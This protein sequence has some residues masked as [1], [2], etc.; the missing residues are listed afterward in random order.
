MPL[1]RAGTTASMPSVGVL[2]SALPS[3]AWAL[4]W[5]LAWALAW[6][7]KRRCLEPKWLR[8]YVLYTS[9]FVTLRRCHAN[10]LCSFLLHFR[11]VT[12]CT[13]TTTTVVYVAFFAGSRQSNL[14]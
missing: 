1:G 8:F 13:T 2:A 10:L 7:A 11:S 12:F 3:V 14:S 6:V 4:P 5:V 9:R